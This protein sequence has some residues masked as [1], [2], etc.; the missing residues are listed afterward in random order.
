[1]IYCVALRNLIS[2][3]NKCKE[4]GHG[5]ECHAPKDC[6]GCAV[7]YKSYKNP[8]DRKNNPI[9]YKLKSCMCEEFVE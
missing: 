5:E 3:G 4:C 1:M 8:E 6:M 7:I 2:M 9:N